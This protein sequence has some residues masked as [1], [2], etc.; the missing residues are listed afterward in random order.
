M[1]CLPSSLLLRH[2]S[3]LLISGCLLARWLKT[4]TG[5][6]DV[7]I[8]N[9]QLLSH[10]IN[11]R[12]SP[13]CITSIILIDFRWCYIRQNPSLDWN[14]LQQQLQRPSHCRKTVRTNARSCR[15]DDTVQICPKTVTHLMFWNVSL[16]RFVTFTWLCLIKP[17]QVLLQVVW[18][19][20]S[21]TKGCN[22]RY[23]RTTFSGLHVSITT[24]HIS[25]LYIFHVSVFKTSIVQ[26]KTL[27]RFH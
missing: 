11:G 12:A 8:L 24:L 20:L 26:R 27:V 5:C 14:I 1:H 10:L 21:V 15:N 7:V 22:W 25:R 13:H 6:K 18:T 19:C 16:F 2:S 9:V 23:L 3:V 17:A 4:V